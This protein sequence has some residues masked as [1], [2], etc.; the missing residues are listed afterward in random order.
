M[1]FAIIL[2]FTSM[3]AWAA[4]DLETAVAKDISGLIDDTVN[5]GEQTAT[6][7][8]KNGEPQVRCTVSVQRLNPKLRWAF[9]RVD[10][11]V[12]YE[13]QSDIRECKLLYSFDPKKV[14]SSLERSGNSFQDCIESLGESIE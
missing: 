9:C 14:L 2:F 10:F 3:P 4:T 7:I 11:K 6:L 5:E 12:E 8:H 13:D 1:L